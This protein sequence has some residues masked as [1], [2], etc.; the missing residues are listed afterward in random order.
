MPLK[1]PKDGVC[2]S[3]DRKLPSTTATQ[4][5]DN[6]RRPFWSFKENTST[7]DDFFDCYVAFKELNCHEY[8]WDWQ[9]RKVDEM[10]IKKLVNIYKAFFRDNPIGKSC[11]VTFR[12]EGEH[13]LEDIGRF[14]MSIISSNDFAAGQ[15]MFSPPVFEVVHSSASSGSLLRFAS[16]YNES[17]GIATEKLRHDCRPKFISIIPTHDFGSQNWYS[18]LNSYFSGFQSSFR[19]KVDYFRPLI[20]RSAVADNAGFVAAVLMT[21]RALSSYSSFSSITGLVSYPIIEAGPLM[22]RGG[23]NP[24]S[25]RNFVDTYPG[26]RTVTITPAFRYDYE[27]EEVK[28]AVSALNRALPRNRAVS[29][30]REESEMLVRLENIFAKHFGETVKSFPDL[31]EMPAAMGSLNK[32]IDRRIHRSFSLYSLGV[33]PEIIGAG[34]AIVE[35]IKEGL[36]KDLER[37]YPNIKQDLVTACRLLNK[38]NLRFLAKTGKVWD[39]ILKDVKLVE[40]YT[41]SSLGPASTDDFLHRNYTSNVFHLWS[42]KK[43]F[44]KDLLAAA[45]LRRCLG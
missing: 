34:R 13:A 43:D 35:C 24:G 9:G 41:D 38:E 45:R 44:S 40:D 23:L 10:L 39:A 18:L 28:E 42:T 26:A 25:F 32:V 2:V 37:M 27:I 3:G 5:P 4:F 19:C 17:V 21:K 8:F 22:F 7:S 20:P 30:S 29:Y 31:A 1:E 14:S 16:L 12:V 11:F 15:R 6:T 36:V 33:P